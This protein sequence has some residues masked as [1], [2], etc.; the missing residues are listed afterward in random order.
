MLRRSTSACA[1][2]RAIPCGYRVALGGATLERGL[3]SWPRK[4]IG[5]TASVGRAGGVWIQGLLGFERNQHGRVV[6]RATVA[7][8]FFTVVPWW[9]DGWRSEPG[10][11][12]TWARRAKNKKPR[13]GVGSKEP[14]FAR[15]VPPERFLLPRSRPSRDEACNP[16]PE[17]SSL[18]IGVGSF[19]LVHALPAGQ[20]H[21]TSLGAKCQALISSMPIHLSSGEGPALSLHSSTWD[22]DFLRRARG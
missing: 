14:S 8:G 12:F 9:D 7:G 17:L 11:E 19:A 20:Y 22:C 10:P 21:D 4:R 15:W 5:C 2:G 6:L 3:V 18:V 16:R 1:R 13:R